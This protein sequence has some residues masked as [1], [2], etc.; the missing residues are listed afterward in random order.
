MLAFLLSLAEM[1]LT[2]NTGH[3]VQQASLA[4]SMASS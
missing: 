3:G 4:A 1:R 2:Q